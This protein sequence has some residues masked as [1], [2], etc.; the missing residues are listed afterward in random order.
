M[1]GDFQQ[2]TGYSPT[3]YLALKLPDGGGVIGD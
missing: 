2:F 3:A 1:I